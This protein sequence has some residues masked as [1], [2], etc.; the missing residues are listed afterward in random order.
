LVAAT[1]IIAQAE[2]AT[3]NQSDFNAFMSHGLKLAIAPSLPA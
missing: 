1:A 2:L 3:A